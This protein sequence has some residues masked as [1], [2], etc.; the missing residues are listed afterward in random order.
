MLSRS[1]LHE[2]QKKTIQF[3]K[4]KK[5]CA[6]FL[7]LGAGKSVSSLTAVS[8]LIDGFTVKHVLVVAPLRVANSV[9]K[10]EAEKWE[11][12]NHLKITVCT[13]S[14][15][16][17]IAAL[18]SDA[19]VYVINRENITWLVEH[20]K[21]KWPF[22]CVIIDEA[23]SFKNPSS[24]RF[25]A[26]KKVLPFTE[27]M[28]LLTGTPS[29]NGL[30]DLWS[31]IYL[32]DFG[33][34]L[35]RTMTAY[36][37]RF[38]ESDFMGY[39]FT[40]RTGA[41]E[42]IQNAIKPLVLSMSAE[43]YLQLPDR[44]DLT[45]TVELPAKVMGQYLD[46]EKTLLAEL[47]GGEE[48]E[49]VSA[50]VL[51]NKLLQLCIGEKT[52]VVTQSGFVEIE[53]ITNE[54][55][56]WDGEKWV[57]CD[58][59]CFKGYKNVVNCYGV[60]MTENHNVLTTCGWATAKEIN[61]G[62]SSKR[63]NREYLRN[64]DC[65]TEDWIKEQ[66]SGLVVPMCVRKSGRTSKSKFTIKAQGARNKIMRLFA[67][68]MVKNARY[69]RFETIR[70]MAKH[71]S[72]LSKRKRQGLSKLRRSW[73]NG[74]SKLGEFFRFFLERH[75]S[76]LFGK[77]YFRQSEQ[78]TRI[79]QRKLPMGDNKGARAKHT[80]INN[81]MDTRWRYEFNERG[82]KIRD[83]NSY[84]TCANIPI[85]MAEGKMVQKNVYDILNCGP[86]NRF[87]VVDEKGV[88]LIVHNCNG[89]IYTD[90]NHNYSETHSAKLDALEE[91]TEREPD[92]NF[93]I[94]YNYKSDLERLQKR[95]PDA[96]VLDKE[97]E[98]IVRWNRGEIKMLLAHP[99][100]ASMGLNLQQGG[101]IIVWFGLTWS[102]EN[103]LQFNARLHRQ[104]Q[105]KPV[106]IVHLVAQGTIDER[107]LKVIAEKDS[108]QNSLLHALKP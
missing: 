70:N 32:L 99:A 10:Q 81:S 85:Q 55:I 13:G 97:A 14:E 1:D 83:K 93:L 95:F 77:T 37:Q 69:D 101:S 61:D 7:F 24:Q 52:R 2:Y 98:T 39:K 102:L 78:R 43:D 20:Y 11:H 8:D 107:V 25:K 46:F 106:R 45:E 21:Q 50:A 105:I 16:A 15:R 17:R 36:K 23:S 51:A 29:P 94:A 84:V 53:N 5:R 71:D 4:D 57:T 19:D 79:Q 6:C 66:Q 26:L 104:G 28:V 44:I 35:G 63:F 87:T 58:G 47:D 86:D 75:A 76:Y 67:W 73:N 12:L 18:Y 68:G 88:P 89:A 96:V 59:V 72:S 74:L 38:F 65:I 103:Y 82:G 49:A 3:I 40:P 27:Y 30:L 48:I 60:D 41:P 100:S 42:Q 33:H 31:Q 34:A 54:D 108:V 56:I 9:W 90:E 64:P 80:K 22:D 91:L 62:Q 92:E